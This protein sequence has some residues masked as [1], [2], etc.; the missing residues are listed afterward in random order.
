MRKTQQIKG[1]ALYL[2]NQPTIPIHKQNPSPRPKNGSAI[3]E[4]IPFHQ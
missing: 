4:K 3:K 2:A 1:N